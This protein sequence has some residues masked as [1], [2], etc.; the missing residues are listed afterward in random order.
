MRTEREPDVVGVLQHIGLVLFYLVL[1]I[2]YL[3]IFFGI[4]GGWIALVAIIIYDAVA[5]FSDVGLALLLVMLGIAVLGEIIE[6]FLGLVYVA[7]KGATK[8][9][10]LGAFA[11][12]L[13]GAIGGSM[14]L[15]FIGSVLLGLLGAFAGAVALEYLYYRS[16]DRALQTG[17]FA[18]VGKLGAMFV[19]FALGLVTLGIF[20]YRSWG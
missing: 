14:I 3:T 10:V 1:F 19:K 13:A 9:G 2:F 7:Q 11:G 20:V 16:M 18:F 12:G 17:F 15:P 6:S 8:W 5:G 4:P